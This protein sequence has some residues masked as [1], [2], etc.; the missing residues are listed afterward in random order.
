MKAIKSGDI[1][2]I[3]TAA[4]NVAEAR[5]NVPAMPQ[6]I[7]DDATPEAF[8]ELLHDNAGRM[9]IM[10][11]E[12]GPFE[13]MAGRY[14]DGNRNR[15]EVYLG[16]WSGDSVRVNRIRREDPIIIEEALATVL[17]TVQPV[18]LENLNEDMR[19]KG[20]TARI[21]YSIPPAQRRLLRTTPEPA[22]VVDTYER[23]MRELIEALS[24]PITNTVSA[25]AE[26]SDLWH[27][28]A[29]D[30]TDRA[31]DGDLQNVAEWV[32]K[33][34]ASVTRVSALLHV[35]DGQVGHISAE[36]MRSAITI[37]NYWL[38][39]ALVVHD[40]WRTNLAAVR[41]MHILENHAGETVRPR[42]VMAARRVMPNR[43]AFDEAIATLIA[44]GGARLV[45]GVHGTHGSSSDAPTYLIRDEL[46]PLCTLQPQRKGSKYMNSHSVVNVVDVVPIGV[47]ETT[48]SSSVGQNPA[49]TR[50]PRHNGH[51]VHNSPEEDQGPE[52]DE[53]RLL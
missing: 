6:L 24:G 1:G 40:L 31:F 16:A 36:T 4:R 52:Y 47:F 11:T 26:A 10:S 20:L 45:D 2:D 48:S 22:E 30:I 27:D 8:A 37:G 29:Q 14:S 34:T 42:E 46:W 7:S 38:S 39:H 41:A 51:N 44:H 19:G 17:V 28:W 21:M 43:E 12:G 13:L 49:Q 5:R 9:A 53:S 33:L 18:V 3:D 35:A 32:G 15:L 25:T 50:E 23:K